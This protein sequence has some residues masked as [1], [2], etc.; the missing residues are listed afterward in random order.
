MCRYI[1]QITIISCLL[2]CFS[3]DDENG[4]SQ[5]PVGE[6]PPYTEGKTISDENWEM[7]IGTFCYP[8]N[9]SE[10]T[11]SFSQY[12]GKVFMIEMSASW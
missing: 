10:S 11:F 1:S 2:F 3:C 12:T 7:E 5:E 4:S 8:S 9:L 6:G